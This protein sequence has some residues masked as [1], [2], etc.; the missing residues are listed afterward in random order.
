MPPMP[1]EESRD[2]AALELY[3]RYNTTPKG[4]RVVNVRK[5]YLFR[6]TKV[7]YIPVDPTVKPGL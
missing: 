5:V 1:Y 4:I 6:R 7:Q 3:A 2:R